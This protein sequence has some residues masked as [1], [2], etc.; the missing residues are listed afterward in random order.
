LTGQRAHA[1]QVVESPTDLA[2]LAEDLERGGRAVLA[3]VPKPLVVQALGGVV[4]R[5]RPVAAGRDAQLVKDV[6]GAKNSVLPP[7][8]R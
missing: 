7:A 6:W 8:N 1:V 2:A 5:P 4:E 3:S